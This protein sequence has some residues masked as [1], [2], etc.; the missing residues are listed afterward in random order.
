MTI[1]HLDIIKANSVINNYIISTET[2]YSH[3]LS[4]LTGCYT[5]V[6]Y[7]NKQHTGSFKIRGALNKMLSLNNIEKLNGVVAMSA[8]NH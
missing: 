2:S 4:E 1:S 5:I 3:S 7:E 8:G 6:K